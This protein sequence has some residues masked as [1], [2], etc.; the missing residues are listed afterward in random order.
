MRARVWGDGTTAGVNINN[1][2]YSDRAGAA[3][4]LE[5]LGIAAAVAAQA[6]DLVV[7]S[8]GKIVVEIS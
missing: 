4:A 7:Q 3:K 5:A 8:N 1:A 6:I 2:Y